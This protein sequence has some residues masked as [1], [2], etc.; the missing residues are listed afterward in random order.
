MKIFKLNNLEIRSHVGSSLTVMVWCLT[1]VIVVLSSEPW[2]TDFGGVI[3]AARSLFDD[4]IG[5]KEYRL[6]TFFR[7]CKSVEIYFALVTKHD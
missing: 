7:F 6:S 4:L 5:I 2:I 3:L 1:H